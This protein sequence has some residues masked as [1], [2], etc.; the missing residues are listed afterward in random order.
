ML[1][2][3][4]SRRP[5]LSNARILLGPALDRQACL[6]YISIGF[7]IRYD[8]S[9]LPVV[10]APKMELL[11]LLETP[12]RMLIKYLWVDN[13]V[14][15]ELSHMDHFHIL[16]WQYL[17]LVWPCSGCNS[18]TR[19]CHLLHP[20]DVC[21]PHTAKTPLLQKAPDMEKMTSGE[22]PTFEEEIKLYE[23]CWI[24]VLFCWFCA[25]WFNSIILC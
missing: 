20:P 7:K 16:K 13:N 9:S 12:F 15:L 24:C 14:G 21:P 3:K 17:P 25:L 11:L 22:A 5:T 1:K 23:S 4:H 18:H 6:S 2:G 10:L 19:R 8:N